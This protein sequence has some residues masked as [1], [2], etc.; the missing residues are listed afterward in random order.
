MI[1]KIK[2]GPQLELLNILGIE[3]QNGKLIKKE[4]GEEF[5]QIKQD[6]IKS[7]WVDT[8]KCGETVVKLGLFLSDNPEVLSVSVFDNG[9]NYHVGQF[10]GDSADRQSIK[11]DINET[12]D[13]YCQNDDCGYIRISTSPSADFMTTEVSLR[14]NCKII[15]YLDNTMECDLRKYDS[16]GSWGDLFAYPS[17]IDEEEY[18]NLLTRAIKYMYEYEYSSLNIRDAYLRCLPILSKAFGEYLHI[19]ETF[20]GEFEQTFAEAEA[21]QNSAFFEDVNREMM[22]TDR[23]TNS[24]TDLAE[25]AKQYVTSSIDFRLYAAKRLESCKKAKEKIN[26]QRDNLKKYIR[27]LATEDAP[28]KEKKP[29]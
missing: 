16:G 8:Y 19:P 23:D 24:Q 11:L 25:A 15:C 13:P 7:T 9:L 20:Q 3:R 4:T 26:N 27:N 5:V 2:K 1:N 10:K 14:K 22:A 18:S 28:K 6:E 17:D 12:D 29:E 21:S